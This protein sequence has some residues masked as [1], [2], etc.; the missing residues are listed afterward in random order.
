MGGKDIVVK[1]RKRRSYANEAD[2]ENE[3]K[4]VI[5]LLQSK[6][7]DPSNNN[8][9]SMGFGR[10]AIIDFRKKFP[11]EKKAKTSEPPRQEEKKEIEPVLVP[12]PIERV[13]T[14][15]PLPYKHY[16][17]ARQAETPAATAEALRQDRLLA[18]NLSF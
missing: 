18:K 17:I 3:I 16:V 13:L 11:R 8:I 9:Q 2:K 7:I 10:T 14:H 6:G 1:K 5:E 15:Y 4:E 12:I